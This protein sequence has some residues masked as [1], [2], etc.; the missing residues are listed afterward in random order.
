MPSILLATDGSTHSRYAAERALDLAQEQDT[1]LHVVCVVDERRFNNP[2]LSTTELLTIFAEDH[3]H[4][5]VKE[6]RQM[7]GDRSLDIHGDIRYGRPEAVIL[8][9]ATEVGADTIVLG[10]HGDHEYHLSGVGTEI[11]ARASQ[12]VIVVGA[13]PA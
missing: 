7:A 9:Y 4:F 3:A 2:A 11:Q 6:V 12:E 10:E 13:E 8:E 5:C 1:T